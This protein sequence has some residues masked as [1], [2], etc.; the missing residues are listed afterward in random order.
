LS[1]NIKQIKP[2]KKEMRLYRLLKNK[3]YTKGFN[4][5]TP[6]VASIRKDGVETAF[7]KKSNRNRTR[8]NEL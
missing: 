4:E 6:F 3:G 7:S 5:D 8:K 2:Q 1:H